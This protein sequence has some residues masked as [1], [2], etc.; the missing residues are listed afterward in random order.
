MRL[1]NSVCSGMMFPE[2]RKNLDA[3]RR[4]AD[5]LAERGAECMEFYYDGPAS[6]RFGDALAANGLD[7]VYVAVIPSKEQKL[8][9][10]DLDED[11][12]RA[13]LDMYKRCVDHAM[14]NGVTQIMISSGALG[15]DVDRQLDALAASVT[16]LYEY[17]NGKDSSAR[18]L[19]EPCDDNMQAYH[20][21]GPYDRVRGF[22]RRVNEAGCPME[23]TMDCAHSAEVGEDF[24]QAVRETKP[25]CRHVHFA[26]CNIS[27]PDNPL[28]GDKHVGFEYPDTEW[29]PR[30]LEA[31]FRTLE[32]IYPGDDE[33]RIGIE[34][35]CRED[36]PY[37]YFDKTWAMLPFL[38]KENRK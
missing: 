27:Q 9:L 17:A 8:W 38:H 23:L 31:L 24:A 22:T 26:N 28:Y 6:D 2:S 29:T 20:L 19:M 35:L 11:G 32:E 18:L 12:R 25:W 37:A 10:C 4:T 36:D 15:G 5:F 14:G 30:T 1:I 33:L 21:L 7:A 16:E 34:I 13:A 3:F